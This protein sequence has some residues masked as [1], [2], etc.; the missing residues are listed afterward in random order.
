MAYT[1]Q[2]LKAY[3]RASDDDDD[4]VEECLNEATELVSNYVGKVFV[5]QLT[6]DLAVKVTGRDLYAQR[7]SPQGVGQFSDLNDTPIRV[8]R[9][10]LTAA[11]P[12]LRKYVQGIA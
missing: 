9:D 8:A 2:Q 5:P 1:W 10:P 6:L 3:I 7:D 11:K 12:I 4:F